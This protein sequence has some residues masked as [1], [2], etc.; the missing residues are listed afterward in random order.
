MASNA[1]GWF[2]DLLDIH[3]PSRVFTQY[4]GF[5]TEGLANG[6]EDDADSPIKQVRGIANNLRNAAGG[7]MLGAG[8]ATNASA[9]NIDTSAIQIDARPP[10]QSHASAAPSAG[11]VIHG[12]INIEVHA[13]PGMDEQA[14]ARMVNEQVQRALKDAERRAAAASR[15]NFYDN[16]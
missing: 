5:I 13:S 3:S 8:L 10:L 7:L 1:M 9:A 12:G 14:L 4:G 6:I 11:L 16:D 15:R 2:R